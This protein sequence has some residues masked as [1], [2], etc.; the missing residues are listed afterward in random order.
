MAV[1]IGR[2]NELESGGSGSGSGSVGNDILSLKVQAPVT[3]GNC[4]AVCAPATPKSHSDEQVIGAG[5]RQEGNPSSGLLLGRTGVFCPSGIRYTIER[6]MRTSAL[7]TTLPDLIALA[8]YAELVMA[9]DRH[10]K[11]RGV[12]V[13]ADQFLPGAG[14]N[15]DNDMARMA[16]AD[17]LIASKL[18]LCELL[19]HAEGSAN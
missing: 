13:E 12:Q 4:V 8:R 11:Q 19:R 9:F 6:Y 15:C 10:R 16:E 17:G 18:P 2:G 3:V 1:R 5:S 7:P 14:R